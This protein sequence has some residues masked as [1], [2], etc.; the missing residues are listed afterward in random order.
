MRNNNS[1][2]WLKFQQSGG[3]VSVSVSSFKSTTVGKNENAKQSCTCFFFSFYCFVA[4]SSGRFGS[5]SEA[6]SRCIKV[7]TR[8]LKTEKKNQSYK[9]FRK[10]ETRAFPKTSKRLWMGELVCGYRHGSLPRGGGPSP[11]DSHMIPPSNVIITCRHLSPDI[12]GFQVFGEFSA[13][14]QHKKCC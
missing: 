10:E 5:V 13:F 6:Y 1:A 3:P 9:I 4:S 12:Q 2:C 7:F 8:G 14:Y 11:W